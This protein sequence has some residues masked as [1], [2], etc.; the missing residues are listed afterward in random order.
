M[1]DPQQPSTPPAW[2]PDPDPANP[3]GQRW[4]D[5]VRWTEH[6]R[7]AVPPTAA[8]TGAP[9]QQNVYQPAYQQPGYQPAYQQ[10]GYVQQMPVGGAVFPRVAPGTSSNT[11]SVWLVVA[12]PLVVIIAFMFVDFT[13]YLRTVFELGSSSEDYSGAAPAITSAMSQYFIM[14]LLI[15]LLGLVAYGLSVLFAYFDHRELQRR[16]FVRPFHWAWTFLGGI[17]YVIGRAVVVNRRGGAHGLWPIWG[18]IAVFVIEMVLIGVKVAMVANSIGSLVTSY[19][20]SF[21]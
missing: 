1:T 14:I 10:P 5:G 12:L 15:D 8:P 6:S 2:Y 16:G 17:V 11:W 20:G 18:L 19:G 13:S 21:S 3:G 9:A 4:W 7:P